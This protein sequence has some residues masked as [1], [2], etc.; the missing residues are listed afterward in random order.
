MEKVTLT[1][2]LTYQAHGKVNLVAL[3]DMKYGELQLAKEGDLLEVE[4]I[5]FIENT[6]TVFNRSIE[7]P[8][9]FELLIDSLGEI[10][11]SVKID[12]KPISELQN[13]MIY[14]GI[15]IVPIVKL[16]LL[17][18][19]Q[20]EIDFLNALEEDWDTAMDKIGDGSFNL[21]NQMIKWGFNVYESE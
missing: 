14:Q 15:E 7:T 19:T 8:I 21:V 2:I 4:G 20:G 9:I 3:V 11:N 16:F 6:I 10:E 5:S 17:S 1:Q 12:L 18:E 13:P